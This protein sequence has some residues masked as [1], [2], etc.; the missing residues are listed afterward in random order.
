M[1]GDTTSTLGSD[2][3]SAV[4]RGALEADQNDQ[5]TL[6]LS[7]GMSV[8]SSAVFVELFACT[9]TYSPPSCPTNVKP[10]RVNHL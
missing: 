1:A 10:E 5:P 6:R 3:E 4:Q 8:R 9:T 7:N 2:E